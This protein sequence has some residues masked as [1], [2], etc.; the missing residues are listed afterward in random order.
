MRRL[1]FGEFVS[2]PKTY[3]VLLIFFSPMYLERVSV[4]F[5]GI[6]LP[7]PGGA[8]WMTGWH[9]HWHRRLVLGH[10]RHQRAC[11]RAL[12]PASA[13]ERVPSSCNTLLIWVHFDRRRNRFRSLHSARQVTSTESGAITRS[14]GVVTSVFS[15]LAS[16]EVSSAPRR[17]RVI[18]RSSARNCPAGTTT[19]AA[20]RR[21]GLAHDFRAFAA[22]GPRSRHTRTLPG[23]ARTAQRTDGVASATCADEAD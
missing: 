2:T 19:S 1:V 13:P 14:V 22:A 23:Q 6:C 4:T 5:T 9:R 15:E 21:S 3:G 12:A 17:T 10:D 20:R 7:A 11:Q 16:G 8:G 18:Y